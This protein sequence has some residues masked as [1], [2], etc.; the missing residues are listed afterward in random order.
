LSFFSEIESKQLFYELKDK[1]GNLEQALIL[2]GTEMQIRLAK[3]HSS[4]T[5]TLDIIPIEYKEEEHS[6]TINI[7]KIFM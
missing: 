6:A 7:E 3:E 4:N 1:E 2:I 5:Y